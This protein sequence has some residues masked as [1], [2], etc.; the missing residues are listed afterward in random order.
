MYVCLYI[1]IRLLPSQYVVYVLTLKVN[2]QFGCWIVKV[3][4]VC[5]RWHVLP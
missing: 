3:Y 2:F 4:G 5:E 1:L